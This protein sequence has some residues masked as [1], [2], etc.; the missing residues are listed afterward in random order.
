MSP[1]FVAPR[2]AVAAICVRFH[3]ALV[4][5]G[6]NKSTNSWGAALA[7]SAITFSPV[8]IPFELEWKPFWYLPDW[9]ATDKQ[10]PQVRGY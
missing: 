5:S 3:D 2:R 6:S 9:L 8:L 1:H 10:P 7:A 4:M